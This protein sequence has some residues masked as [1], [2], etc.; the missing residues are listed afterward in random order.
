MR[1]PDQRQVVDLGGT[2]RR[3]LLREWHVPTTRRSR[4]NRRVLDPLPARL[5][6]PDPKRLECG[7]HTARTPNHRRL[8]G[9]WIDG[10]L[11]IA[12]TSVELAVRTDHGA[13][14]APAHRLD[15]GGIDLASLPIPRPD[16]LRPS[17]IRGQQAVCAIDES[18]R[19][20]K[21][22]GCVVLEQVASPRDRSRKGRLVTS[23][24]N[25]RREAEVPERTVVLYGG[26]PRWLKRSSQHA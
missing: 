5:H 2:K 23:P 15:A 4:W 9:S 11:D 26:S 17:V 12:T 25:P 7:N 24:I 6:E 18:G 22:A 21:C 8:P 10:D 16:V 14:G 3:M 20:T 19:L 1:V 13:A